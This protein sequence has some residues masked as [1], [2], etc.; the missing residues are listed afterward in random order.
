MIPV[1]PSRKNSPV[2]N[3]FAKRVPLGQYFDKASTALEHSTKRRLKGATALKPILKYVLHSFRLPALNRNFTSSPFRD[4]ES[5]YIADEDCLGLCQERKEAVYNRV[6][7][8][9]SR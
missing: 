4:D 3:Q 8:F 7:T 2:L 9:Y 6:L 5:V 1:D